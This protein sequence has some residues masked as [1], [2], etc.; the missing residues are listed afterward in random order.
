[1]RTKL[2]QY[3]IMQGRDCSDRMDPGSVFDACPNDCSGAGTCVMG[4]CHCKGGMFGADCSRT[5]VL[6]ASLFF[7]YCLFPAEPQHEFMVS[8]V[9]R[10]QVWRFG[11][12]CCSITAWCT[13]GMLGF[14]LAVLGPAD[15]E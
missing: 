13:C 4:F 5:K 10:I 2:N 6:P 12:T 3:P 7:R 11:C 1:M 9:Q 15:W 8:V 14:L